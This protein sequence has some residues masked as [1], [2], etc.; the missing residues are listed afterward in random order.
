V[1]AS[2]D[3]ASEVPCGR[4]YRDLKQLREFFLDN[5]VF[6]LRHHAIEVLHLGYHWPCLAWLPPEVLERVRKYLKKEEDK[7]FVIACATF[8]KLV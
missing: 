6:K 5:V 8:Q 2:E 7:S 4:R 3:P 1:V